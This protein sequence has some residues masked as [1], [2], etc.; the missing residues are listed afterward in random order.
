[1]IWFLA[2]TQP[3][4]I[5]EHPSLDWNI[6]EQGPYQVG[7]TTQE[8]AYELLGTTRQS[9]INIW[10]PTEDSSGEEAVY[11]S[12]VTDEDSFLDASWAAPVDGESFPLLIFSHGSWLYGASSSFLCRHF[13]SHGWVVAAADHTG[14]LLT[15]Y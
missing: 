10:Y 9:T 15:D 2:C 11:F 7:Y 3:K 13:A 6:E 5:V 12:I 4:E 14:H 8:V 1:M